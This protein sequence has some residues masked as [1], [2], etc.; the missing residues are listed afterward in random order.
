MKFGL[1]VQSMGTTRCEAFPRDKHHY[2]DYSN[3]EK[4]TSAAIEINP[5][6]IVSGCNDFASITAAEV[7]NRLNKPTSLSIR[8]ARLLHNKA[9]WWLVFAKLG[10]PVPETAILD[11]FDEYRKVSQHK[12][13]MNRT[14]IL[15]PLDL[16]GGKGIRKVKESLNEADFETVIE[17][18]KASQVLL[19]EFVNGTLHSAMMV[20]SRKEQFVMFADEIADKN[21]QVRCA[22]VPSTVPREKQQEI[23]NQMR[24]VARFL[25]LATGILHIQFIYNGEEHFVIDLC[26][27]PPGDLYI[28]LAHYAFNFD[29]A[30]F[31]LMP[32]TGFRPFAF[33]GTTE[34]Y[35]RLVGLSSSN[36]LKAFT[37]SKI[38][39]FWFTTLSE[40]EDNPVSSRDISF[41][42]VDNIGERNLI[43][44]N[45]YEALGLPIK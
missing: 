10:I 21:N 27:R 31:W 26:G 36:P 7:S 38:S 2:I 9:D 29:V 34:F 39:D 15:K 40:F 19:Q 41:Y 37:T 25:G 18:S 22:T 14:M 30:A 5:R 20:I 8:Q 42:K 12:A 4:V 17:K 33:G 28:L 6:R 3:L 44:N 1:T 45:V 43:V 23:T 32:E 24:K 13:W 11:S 35:M 16:T